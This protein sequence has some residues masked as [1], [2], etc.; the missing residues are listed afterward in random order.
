MQRIFNVDKWRSLPE[1]GA[2]TF[3]N[4]RPRMV[5]LEVNT[6][7]EAQLW[8]ASEGDPNP[9]LLGRV[10]GRDTLEFFPPAGPFDLMVSGSD[11]F[12][13]TSDGMDVS[14]TA[15]APVIFTKVKER[16]AMSPEFRRMAELMN[17]N[18][19]R[20]L[21]QQ[22]HDLDRLFEER[23]RARAA[24]FQAAV[25]GGSVAAQPASADRAGSSGERDPAKARGSRKAKAEVRTGDDG[26]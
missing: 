11:A 24:Q 18:L 19:N 7:G 10:L 13:Y 9:V 4:S 6:P 14:H 22:A 15:E 2:V 1:G 5:R 16:R 8:I 23:E 3:A 25:S 21:Q 17:A 12:F 26:E 20:R